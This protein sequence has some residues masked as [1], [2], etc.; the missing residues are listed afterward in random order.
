[1]F[2]N[3]DESVKKGALL[4]NE[5]VS[6]RA[7]SESDDFHKMFRETCEKVGDNITTG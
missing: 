4:P 3:K 5:L 2:I 1:M 6:T 7:Y